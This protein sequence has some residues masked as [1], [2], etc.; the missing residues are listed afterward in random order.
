[1]S[2]QNFSVSGTAIWDLGFGQIN[3]ETMISG[4]ALE[5]IASQDGAIIANVLVANS[6]QAILSFLY[7][8]LNSLCTS[9]FLAYEWSRFGVERRTLR[10][11]EPKGEQRKTYFLQL[12]FRFAIPLICMSGFLHYLVSQSIFLAVV[13]Q[14]DEVGQLQNAVAVATCGYSPL[15]MIFVMLCGAAIVTGLAI[16]SWRRLDMG[17]PIVSSCSAAIAA[18]CHKPPGDYENASEKAVKWGVVEEAGVQGE[19]GHCSFTSL[20]VSK[21]E[22]GVAYAGWNA[23]VAF[24]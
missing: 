15:A 18:A 5:N 13:S 22:Y 16:L 8:V 14:W 23:G 10:T 2:S 7:F 20:P 11:S 4:W 21:P 6:P 9:M 24:T 12:P 3:S 19:F 1:M 17:I